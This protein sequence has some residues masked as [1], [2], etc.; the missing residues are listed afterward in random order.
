MLKKFILSLFVVG[1]SAT[2]Y[3]QGFVNFT[4]QPL[5]TS[6]LIYNSSSQLASNGNY[7]VQ[8]F[9]ANGSG[10]SEALL[11][12]KGV[13]VN[14]RGGSANKGYVQF[15]G[16]T[17]FNGSTVDPSVQVTTQSSGVVTLQ[18]RAWSSAFPDYAAALAAS[19]ETGKSDLGLFGNNFAPGYAPLQTPADMTGFVGF[20]MVPE[21]STI[22]LGILG[23]SSLFFVRRRK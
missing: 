12:A 4:T 15:S 3:G 19:A 22:A 18:V 11:T 14:F 17:T 21:P 1:A 9:A 20:T 13:P 7:F 16:T 23:A 10:V 8:L 5:G 6:A 2:V